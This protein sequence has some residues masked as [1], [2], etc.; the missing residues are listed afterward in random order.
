VLLKEYCANKGIL[1][2]FVWGSEHRADPDL[3]FDALQQ[4]NVEL[5]DDVLAEL[6]RVWELA[7]RGFTEG[8]LNEARFH[9]DDDAITSISSQPNHEAHA[10]WVFLKRPNYINNGWVIR[11]VDKISPGRWIKRRGMPFRPGPVDQAMIVRLEDALIAFFTK[12]QFRGQSC[13]IDCLRRGDEEIFFAYSQDHP[14]T[15][16]CWE[17]GKLVSVATYPSFSF[18]LKHRDADQTLDIY[19]ESDNSVVPALQ[20]I[21]AR[22]LLG[23]DI[24]EDAGDDNLV[25]H[26]ERMLEPG[27]EFRHSPD[28]GIASVSMTKMRFVVHGGTWRRFFAEADTVTDKDALHDFVSMLSAQFPDDQLFL[29]QVWLRVVFE[30][31]AGDRRAVSRTFPITY[32]NIVRL[33]DDDFANSI[34]QMLAQSGIETLIKIPADAAA[35]R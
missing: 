10:F 35:A 16:L 15:T 11:N 26:L 12:N 32:P 22:E 17:N 20:M 13:K 24:P 3:F 6:K 8:V 9:Q 31:R 25:Y 5:F 34:S 30:R 23:E 33:K 1:S 21:F 27:F 7:E 14:T 4:G 29:D 28:L 19:V 18:V 2:Q